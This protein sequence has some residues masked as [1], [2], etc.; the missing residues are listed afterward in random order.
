VSFRAGLLEGRRLVLAGGVAAG[1]E[2]QL[3]SLGAWTESMPDQVAGDEGAAGE[4]VGERTPLHGLVLDAG[5]AFGSGGQR[6]LTRS[7][8]LAWIATR[9][10]AT[11]ALIPAAD[12]AKVTLIAPAP[13]AGPHAQAARAG[14]ENLART[15]SVEWARFAITTVAVCPGPA[16]ADGDVAALVCFLHSRAGE[17]LSGC[18]LDLDA[19]ADPAVS[20]PSAPG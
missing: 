16:T 19:V 12:P 2:S 6:G 11:G 4:W 15:L 9:A 8:R 13:D 18:R 3:R 1:T 20:A 5:P 7:L 17:Y 10:A 14:L